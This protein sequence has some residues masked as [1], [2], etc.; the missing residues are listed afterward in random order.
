M[1]TKEMNAE[2]KR[3]S[4]SRSPSQTLRAGST[5]PRIHVDSAEDHRQR[6]GKAATEAAGWHRRAA[7]TASETTK[8]PAVVRPTV[9]VPPIVQPAVNTNVFEEWLQSFDDPSQSSV[10]RQALASDES[11]KLLREQLRRESFDFRFKWLKNR[12]LQELYEN[13]IYFSAVGL[14]AMKT[15][16]RRDRAWAKARGIGPTKHEIKQRQTAMRDLCRFYNVDYHGRSAPDIV[17]LQRLLK[18]SDVESR[19]TDKESELPAVGRDMKV[20]F[21]KSLFGKTAY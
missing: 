10:K 18:E 9:E 16:T 3:T 4:T 19:L 15:A 21:Q 5:L 7:A 8:R 13:R 17:T 11:M 20:L 1:R 12:P 2:E 14:N 6:G